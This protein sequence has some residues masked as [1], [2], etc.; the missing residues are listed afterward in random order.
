MVR[1]KKFKIIAHP[2]QVLRDILSSAEIAQTTL[3]RHLHVPA[4]YVNEICNGKRGLS[5]L[6]AVKLGRVFGQ[7][8]EM[9]MDIQRDWEL[10]RIS[11]DDLDVEPF[12]KYA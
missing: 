11:E 3:A 12:S 4:S 2:G 5:P 10:S 9:W 6:M 1:K 7:S 8:P